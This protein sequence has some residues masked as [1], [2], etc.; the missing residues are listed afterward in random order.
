MNLYASIR[1]RKSC[2]K[3]DMQP[4]P[5]ST[6]DEIDVAIRSFDRLYPDV[7][8]RHRFVTKVKGAFHVEAPHYL[9]IS[10]EGMDGEQESCG[11]LYEQLCLWLDAQG[12]GCVWLGASKAADGN[13][14]KGDII[15]IAFGAV[16]EPVH[17]GPDGFKRRPIGDIT[18]APE[19]IRMQ[20]VHLAPSGMNTQPWYFQSQGDTVQVYRQKLKPPISLMY[21]HTAVDMGIAL[22]HYMLACREMDKPFRFTRDKGLPEKAGY[23]S[24]G[25]IR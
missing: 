15:T 18:N 12:L 23:E 13:G 6:L 9:I 14:G 22:C 1:Q 21:R 7:P 5:Q 16:T 2:R 25:V 8:V 19:D 10:G 11:F 24:F 4:L 20:A 17:R 3:Y